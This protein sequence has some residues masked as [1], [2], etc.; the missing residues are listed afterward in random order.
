MMCT[1]RVLP[2]VQIL[3]CLPSRRFPRR[4]D[5]ASATAI[6]APGEEYWTIKGLQDQ[7]AS[8]QK[9]WQQ[10][11]WELHGRVR[12]LTSELE[13]LRAVDNQEHCEVCGRGEPRNRHAPSLD[14][15]QP[16]KVGIVNRPRARTGD[17]ARFANGN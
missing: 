8:A 2:R 15:Q 10:Q 4:S 13:D 6:E 17:T 9:A 11:I 3:H 14:E 7:L 5:D 12:D 1:H 16:K